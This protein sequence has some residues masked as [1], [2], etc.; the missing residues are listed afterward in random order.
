[1]FRVKSNTGSSN[2]FNASYLYANNTN[3]N[4]KAKRE[5]PTTTVI[6]FHQRVQK[7]E[8]TQGRVTPPS[9]TGRITPLSNSYKISSVHLLGSNDKPGSVNSN[10]QA[11]SVEKQPVSS[12]KKETTKYTS[13]V[14]TAT[15][16]PSLQ[17]P[18]DSKYSN[19]HPPFGRLKCKNSVYE[20]PKTLEQLRPHLPDNPIEVRSRADSLYE[21]SD[22][23][24]VKQEENVL[25]PCSVFG[26]DENEVKPDGI[27]HGSV[28]LVTGEFY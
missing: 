14:S 27:L 25:S 13:I 17:T 4:N 20:L 1:M 10:S 12:V 24:S 9:L 18:T 21:G 8:K 26:D 16:S 2:P 23:S 7:V 28:A 22:P 11:S 3:S 15:S 5:T 6:N 19:K